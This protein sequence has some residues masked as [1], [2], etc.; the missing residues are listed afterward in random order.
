M[1]RSILL[2]FLLLLLST[3]LFSCQNT[4][5][6]TYGEW[7]TVKDATC[8]AGGEE[9]RVCACGDSE[10]KATE[11]LAHTE[12]TDAAVAATC[13]KTG[14]SEGKH[15]SVCNTVLV[16]QTVTERLPHTEI[17]ENAVAVSC[18]RPGASGT[19]TCSQ[20]SSVL[21]ENVFLLPGGHSY[22]GEE[23]T[24]CHSTRIEY[25]DISLYESH[26]AE[27][28]FETA[29]NGAAMRALYREMDEVLSR[30]HSDHLRN[31]SYYTTNDKLGDLFAVAGF[32]YAQYGLSLEEAK[33]VYTLFRKDHPLFYWISYWL[34]W[35]ESSGVI[36]ITTVSEFAN[37]YDRVSYNK[38]VY[39]GIAA[40]HALADG[41]TD[42]YSIALIYYEAILEN[43]SYA[44]DSDG[45]IEAAQ[46]AHSIIGDFLY[47][48]FV[49]EGY[50]KLFQLLLNLHGIENLF[51]TGVTR[52]S[53]AWNLVRL[54]D[55]G[56]YWFDLT[57]GDTSRDP[58]RYFCATDAALE[59]SHTPTPSYT[60]GMYTN[61]ALPERADTAYTDEAALTLGE[62]VTVNGVDY[63]LSSYH[64]L[65]AQKKGTENPEMLVYHGVVYRVTE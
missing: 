12:V 64:T 5:I 13:Q 14:L 23:C 38:R 30:F 44:Y 59:Q 49:C 2:L 7:V 24:V 19:V 16:A 50:A 57:F 65:T 63:T 10:T 11:A 28:F 43:N 42:P 51:V 22:V 8:K 31:A 45:G 61:I 9:R 52:G 55:G 60:Y 4:H 40:Y 56:W 3:T 41:E 58:Y 26:E 6:H 32:D 47:D 21:S 46:W 39:E 29:E 35:N 48:R 54:G 34:Y 27:A 37:G 62:A 25:T 53:H 18:T 36:I 15:C 1:K 17:T 20:C 33:T